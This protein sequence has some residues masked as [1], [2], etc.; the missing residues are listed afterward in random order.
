MRCIVECFACTIGS[1]HLVVRDAVT[2][3]VPLSFDIQSLEITSTEGDDHSEAA[4]EADPEEHLYRESMERASR[5][6]ISPI[7]VNG[8]DKQGFPAMPVKAVKSSPHRYRAARPWI[9]NALTVRPM[10][11]VRPA[12]TRALSRPLVLDGTSYAR[13]RV[14]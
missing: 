2:T 6:P 14:G 4:W 12:P 10:T 11:R 3:S 5:F 8:D 13:P 1:G 7:I 9:P